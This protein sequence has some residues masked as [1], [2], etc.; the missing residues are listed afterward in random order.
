MQWRDA[1]RRENEQLGIKL[2]TKKAIVEAPRLVIDP[3]RSS[4]RTTHTAG[5]MNRLETSYAAHLELRK[6]TGEI[7]KWAFEPIKLRLA[8]ATFYSIDFSVVFPDGH[9]ELH[10]VKGHWEDDAR[11]K[12]KVAAVMFDEY[13]FVGVQWVKK[14]GWKFEYFKG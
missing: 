5:E 6:L 12:V 9:I 2:S 4:G 7:R 3:A 1:V 11:V 8:P 10:E 14:T 13:R